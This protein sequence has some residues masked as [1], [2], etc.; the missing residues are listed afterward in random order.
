MSVTPASIDDHA[1]IGDGRSVALVALDGTIDWL[2]WPT[3]DSPAIFSALLDPAAGG[4]WRISTVSSAQMSRRYRDDTNVLETRF[5]TAEGVAVLTDAMTFE[6]DECTNVHELVRRLA[7]ERGSVEVEVELALRPDFARRRAA[8]RQ[9]GPLGLRLDLGSELYAVHGERTLEI[10]GD[11]GRARFVIKQGEVVRF[12]LTF[13]DDIASIP[14]L[15]EHADARIDA[16]AAWW[17]SWIAQLTYHGPDRAIV[18]RSLLAIKL[19]SFAPSGAVIAAATTSLPEGVGGD[20]NWDYRYCW[21]RDASF[22][23]RAFYDFGF[24]EDAV[25]FCGWLLHATRLTRPELRILYDVYGKPPEDEQILH[26]LPGYRESRPVRIHNAASSQ[27]QLDCYGEV[28]DAATWLHANEG[29]D[30][31]TQSLLADLGRYVLGHWHLPDHGIWEHRGPPQH[32]THSRVLCWV[33]LD[34]LASLRRQGLVLRLDPDELDHACRAIHDDVTAHAWN[35]SIQSYTDA[36][37]STDLDASVILLPYYG[38]ESASSPRM[39]ATYARMNERLRAAPGLYWRNERSVKVNEGAF[40]ICSAW[41]IDYLVRAGKRREARDVFDAFVACGN[42]LGLFAE[43]VEPKTRAALGNFPQAYTH[44][45]LLA[46]A[47]GI[48]GAA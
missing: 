26:E 27:L 10:S 38:F 35:D 45:G 44:V 29:L 18:V 42:D 6:G 17:R 14:L 1:A 28:L 34:R 19:L 48:G 32:H 21:L 25:A 13:D 43:E 12:S 40:G 47:L 5:E 39:A 15:G 37:G 24:R 23:A 31:E 22:T 16:A 3:F 30:R 7:C 8:M 11:V 2:C 36:Y 41:V 4:Y 33:A 9:A 46:A 20:R